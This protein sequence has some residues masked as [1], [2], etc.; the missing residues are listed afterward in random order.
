MR[1]T[2]FCCRLNNE[3]TGTERAGQA[4]REQRRAPHTNETDRHPNTDERKRRILTNFQKI[5]DSQG[6]GDTSS[7]ENDTQTSMLHIPIHP[8]KDG[9]RSAD[10]LTLIRIRGLDDGK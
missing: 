4:S 10:E 7:K 5:C 6:G 2:Q 8:I 3:K 1:Y 9:E